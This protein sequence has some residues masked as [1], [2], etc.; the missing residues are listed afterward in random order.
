MVSI[1]PDDETLALGELA[2]PYRRAVNE[3]RADEGLPRRAS[4]AVMAF[5]RRRLQDQRVVNIFRQP[6]RL[7]AATGFQE[8]ERAASL[9]SICIVS[10]L[11]LAL[12]TDDA[13]AVSSQRF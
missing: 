7:A 2:C 10:H 5:L 6:A 11:S 1:A 3:L 12:R 9:P 13:K 4:E 8:F